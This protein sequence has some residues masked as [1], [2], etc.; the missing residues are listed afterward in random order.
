MKKLMRMFGALT[1]G[2][3]LS[4]FLGSPALRATENAEPAAAQGE[5]LQPGARALEQGC[6]LQA[7]N[8]EN[9]SVEGPVSRATPA[10]TLDETFF[11]CVSSDF[12]CGGCP[13][14][15]ICASEAT[16]D[17]GGLCCTANFRCVTSCSLGGCQGLCVRLPG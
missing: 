11:V 10:T 12:L 9:P 14:G 15:T 7:L 4:L 17:L 16:S 13:S 6:D 8:I 5:L 2:V 3:L 1:L